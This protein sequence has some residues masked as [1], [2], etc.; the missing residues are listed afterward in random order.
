MSIEYGPLVNVLFG[1]LSNIDYFFTYSGIDS[2]PC[3][4]AKE[5]SRVRIRHRAA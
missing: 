4:S 2:Q 3:I 1:E 5:M